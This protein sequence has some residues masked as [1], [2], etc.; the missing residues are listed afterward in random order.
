VS[1][2]YAY[3]LLPVSASIIAIGLGTLAGDGTR[4][5]RLR[6]AW[7]AVAACL[8]VGNLSAAREKAGMLDSNGW[9]ATALI[10]DIVPFAHEV[11]PG[12]ELVLLHTEPDIVEYS[13]FRLTGFDVLRHAEFYIARRAGR[14]DITVTI[15]RQVQPAPGRTMLVLDQ[16]KVREMSLTGIRP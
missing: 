5:R 7:M 13:M 6:L 11:A 10:E 12:G 3:Q 15:G 14:D 16:D 9:R 4:R 8:I 1:E 2:L